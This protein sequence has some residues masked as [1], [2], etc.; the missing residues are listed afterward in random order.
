MNANLVAHHYLVAAYLT[1]EEELSA[2]PDARWAPSAES[3]ALIEVADF[4]TR[5]EGLLD[6]LTE[7]AIGHDLWLTR[8]GHGTG[9]WDRDL[10]EQGERL[11]NIAQ[12]MGSQ[13]AYVGDDGLIYLS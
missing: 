9:F 5:A 7:A 3:D 2:Y 10:G 13:D 11:A 12:A 1:E 6:G 4:L 8:N